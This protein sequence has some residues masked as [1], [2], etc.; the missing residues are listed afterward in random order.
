MLKIDIVLH[1]QLY[2]SPLK[3]VTILCPLTFSRA[4]LVVCET[5][6]TELLLILTSEML[7]LRLESWELSRSV[8]K[9]VQ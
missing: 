7:L 5:E 8:E 6:C 1:I 4:K 2:K 9:Y 3:L